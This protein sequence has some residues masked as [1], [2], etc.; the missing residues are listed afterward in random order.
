M[1]VLSRKENQ[2]IRFPDLDVTVEILRVKGSAVRVG[3]DAPMEIRIL[4]DEIE[5]FESKPNP[6]QHI[7]R[8]PQSE[9][10]EV[11]NKLNSLSIALHL[12][13]QEMVAGHF[14]DAQQTFEKVFEQIQNIV[15]DEK[16]PQEPIPAVENPQKTALLVEDEDNEREMLAGFL[17]LHGYEVV[18]ASNGLEAIDYLESNSKPSLVLMDMRMPRCDGP[19]TIRR[20]RENPELEALKIFAISG[21]SPEENQFGNLDESI[22][23]WFMKPLDPRNLVAAMADSL[24][25]TAA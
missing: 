20:I 3:V 11:R 13:K 16:T 25:P 23:Q 8:L 22:D 24:E 14:D 21:S 12:C 6:Q 10:H 15:Q 5:E 9:R 1:L 19:T 7:V 17:R 4:R 2:K 18:T